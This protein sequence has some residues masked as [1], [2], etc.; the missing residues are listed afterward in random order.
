MCTFHDALRYVASV[1][2][3]PSLSR[4]KLKALFVVVDRLGKA[5]RVMSSVSSCLG[6]LK[7]EA[8]KGLLEA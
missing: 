4:V 8:S 2:V 7:V 5:K 1:V 6:K 3:L